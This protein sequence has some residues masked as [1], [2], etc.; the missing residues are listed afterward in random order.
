MKTV[1]VINGVGASGKDTFCN[2]I[3]EK[4]KVKNVSSIDPIKEIAKSA[5]WNGEKTPESRKLLS[6]L[7]RVFTEY[8]ELPNNYIVEQYN[9]FMTSDEEIMFVH[10]RECAEIEKFK[11][12]ISNN[13][14]TLLVHRPGNDSWGNSSDDDVGNMTYDFYYENNKKMEEMPED[15]IEFFEK[16]II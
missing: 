1:I 6:E 4:Y 13:C 11:K 10:I 3:A 9:D 7:K 15:V 16:N 8:N 12:S 2:I 14:K 5:G